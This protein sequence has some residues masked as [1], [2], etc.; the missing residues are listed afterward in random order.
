MA[1]KKI[2]FSVSD[3][4]QMQTTFAEDTPEGLG[5]WYLKQG[6]IDQRRGVALGLRTLF[7]P[8][9]AAMKGQSLEQVELLIMSAERSF[10]DYMRRAREQA[11]YHHQSLL[12][13][14]N[15]SVTQPIEESSEESSPSVLSDP[16][17]DLTNLFN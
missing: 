11:Q 15:P 13:R 8:V 3:G 17:E 4:L 6:E 9:G 14:P 10:E 1:K 16:T 5:A 2:R 12:G 7:A